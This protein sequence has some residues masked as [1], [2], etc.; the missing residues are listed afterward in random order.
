M[1]RKVSNNVRRIDRSQC[2]VAAR[3]GEAF[4]DFVL[5]WARALQEQAPSSQLSGD[6]SSPFNHAVQLLATH[7]RSLPEED[8]QDEEE[9]AEESGEGKA[10]AGN[11]RGLDD[12]GNTAAA[13]TKGG[14]GR[15]R[16]YLHCYKHYP[17]HFS[18]CC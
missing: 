9:G 6:V 17:G 1:R 8:G 7:F 15:A 4:D 3:A 2:P 14:N 11:G 5:L 10:D 12:D 16:I 18:R 13:A